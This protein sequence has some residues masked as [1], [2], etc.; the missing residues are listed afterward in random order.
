MSEHAITLRIAQGGKRRF[1]KKKLVI[2]CTEEK[3]ARVIADSRFQILA[4]PNEIPRSRAGMGMAAPA[5]RSIRMTKQVFPSAE[6]CRIQDAIN[7]K[8]G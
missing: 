5:L 4:L 8:A 1:L 3:K 6:G 2:A 7:S